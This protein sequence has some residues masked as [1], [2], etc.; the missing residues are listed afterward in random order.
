MRPLIGITCDYLKPRF[1]INRAY[2]D[3]VLEAG[4][5]PVLLPHSGRDMKEVVERLDGVLITGGADM[6]T[7]PLGVPL[8]EKAITIDPRRQSGEFALLK[9]LEQRPDLPVLGIC[10][11]MQLMG[12]HAGA[13]L[14]QHL[15]DT[16]PGAECHESDRQHSVR[17]EFGTG[18]VISAHHQGL[19]DAGSMRVTGH[20]P[21]GVIEA[22]ADPVRR[23]YVGV[24]WH[25]ERTADPALGIGVIRALIVAAE[26]E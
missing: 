18:G 7:R 10:L 8:H 17:S 11:G 14:L 15:L 5:L 21:D 1:R 23:F 6:D 4:G 3:C 9:A 25:P 2:V 16:V 12:V 26:K 13:V 22:I 24:Q 20:A 19:A